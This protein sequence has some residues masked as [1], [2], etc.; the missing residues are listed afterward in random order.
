MAKQFLT[1]L[2]L[3]KNELLNARIQNLA[4]APSSPVAGQIYYDTSDNTLRYYNGTSWLTL[5]QGGDLTSAINDAIAALDL[6]NSYDAFG[7]ADTAYSNAVSYAD[8]LASNYDP[9]GSAANA[10][11]NAVSY[12]D[13]LASNYDPAGSA[14]NAYAN[15]QTYTNT[16]ASGLTSDI[17]N[18]K[19]EAIAAAEGYADNA[20]AA[21]V[22]SAPATLDTLNEL[23]QAL[24]DNPNVI[25]DLQDVASGK[26]NTLTAGDSIT[27]VGDVISVVEANFDPAGSAANAQSNAQSYTDTAINALDTDD[28]EEGTT[29]KYFTNLRAKDAAGELLE[30]AIKTNIQISYS[31][32]SQQ[33]T[34]T[35]ENGVADSTTDDLVEGSN[36]LYFTN[37]RAL[38]AT[39]SAYDALGSAANAYAN[40]QTYT[41]TVV[42]GLTSDDISEGST[43]LYH[44]DARS[45]T[46]ISAGDNTINYNSS[47]GEITA[48]TSTMAT[49]AYVDQEISDVG[50]AYAQA[51]SDLSNTLT[52]AYQN[53]DN[54]LSNALTTAYQNADNAVVSSLTQDYQ[55]ADNTVLSTLRSEIA[56]ATQGLDIKESVRAAT[57]ESINIASYAGENIDGVTIANGNRI[58]VKNQVN[59]VENGIYVFSSGALSRADDAGNGELTAGSFTFVEEGTV[60]ADTGWVISTNNPITVGS[61]AITWT[62]FSGT[63]QITAGDGLSKTNGTLDVNVD[64]TTI[65]IVGDNVVISS[66]YAGQSSIDTVGTI[67]TGTWNGNTIAVGY[68]G[69]GAT[70]FTAGEYLVGDGSNAITTVSSIPGSDISGDISG[71][72]ENVNG[73]VAIANGGTGATTAEAARANLGATTKYA[74]NNTLLNPTSNVITWTVTHNLNTSDVTVQMR[75]LGDNAL[76]EADVV[77]TSAN[78]VT[79]QWVS[80]TAVSADAY[81]VVVTG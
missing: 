62:Q 58:L 5:A 76:V 18:A 71:N 53:A 29:N 47:T 22:D 44:T 63:G 79:I 4:V 74:A 50:N 17:A 33:L 81:R 10:Y 35:A 55:D 25:S 31:Q 6:P 32:V 51:D 16:V 69:T 15:A 39:S 57:T 49:V 52:T 19:S 43:N 54:A 28:I 14:A 80:A 75:D 66:S 23:A 70:S 24:Q 27:I 45:R 34:V 20:I 30:N 77:I 36:N 41:N 42:D 37:Q 7:S 3:N 9:A 46:S 48:N 67:T 8:G 56:A 40:A 13:G 65:D 59:S 73:T 64:G 26:Q 72:A 1:G 60:N 61:T 2:N 68:G 11:S 38:N 21:L 78:V 12:A